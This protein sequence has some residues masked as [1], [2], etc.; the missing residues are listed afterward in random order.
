MKL[1]FR[2]GT[3]KRVKILDYQGL[4]LGHPAM[5]IWT[6]IYSA[7]DAEYRATHLENDLQAYYAVFSTYLD[8]T[9]DY[10]EFRQEVEEGRVYGMVMFGEFGVFFAI[11]SLNV[12][13]IQILTVSS[14]QFLLHDTEP[15]EAAEPDKRAVQVLGSL[16]RNTACRGDTGGPSGHQGDSEEGGGQL[17]RDGRPWMDLIG[18]QC[19]NFKTDDYACIINCMIY[20]V[21]VYVIFK[22]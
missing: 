18:D 20:I 14:R 19:Y 2:P 17:D 8:T 4:T 15:N 6:I 21:Y 16:Q 1:D 7:T 5:D 11:I 10:A 22:I 13:I 12:Y 3:P 9:V